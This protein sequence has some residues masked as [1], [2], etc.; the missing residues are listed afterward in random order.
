M[1]SKLALSSIHPGRYPRLVPEL[2]RQI[3][4]AVARHRR[5]MASL[6][7]ELVRIP[8][9][10]PP[11]QNY[12][13]CAELLA[14]RMCRLGLA[15][16]VEK[17]PPLKSS[18][19]NQPQE[20]AAEPRYSVRASYG[21]GRPALYFHGH[22]DV[23]PA[24]SSAQFRARRRNSSIYGRGSGDMKAG[25]AAMIYA[26][27]ALMD[28]KFKLRGRIEIVCVPD[29]ETGGRRGTA[30]LFARGAIGGHAVAMLT[31]EPTG[32]VIWNA[33]R[34]AVSL[35]VRIK[36]KPAHVGL[37]FRGVNAF[38]QMLAVARAF[39]KEK[40]RVSRRSTRYRIAPAA[41]R[42][43]ILLI[44][45]RCEGGVNFNAVPADCAFTLDRRINPEENLAAEK[46]RL[47]QTLARARRRGV[48]LDW[49]IIQQGDSAGLAETH[50][51]ARTLAHAA[52][53]VTGRPCAFEMCP[54][55]LET[56]FYAAR[57]IPALAYGPGLLSV[58]HGPNEFVSL[59]A[60]ESCA[61]V[62]AL[63]AACLLGE[64]AH[65]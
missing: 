34:G 48:H 37:S 15:A 16:R 30:A 11:G 49:E 54:G 52:Q 60:M 22:Y 31:P 40:R 2:V 17:I 47:L 56:R 26:V 38:E 39:E 8:T 65:R 44:G 35:R 33:S 3:R 19:A 12:R 20:P 53:A 46:A 51:V 41:A 61:V 24:S 25:L 36:G 18:P 14:R 42:R 5:A 23:V 13:A 58:A 63:V 62:Y 59:R 7:E 9:E 6:T 43:S 27:R 57:G 1:A 45:G 55:L 29:E 21:A 64:E 50:P 10:N 32:G 28:L 4:R